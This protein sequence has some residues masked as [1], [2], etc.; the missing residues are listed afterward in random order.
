MNIFY[1]G[2]SG[3]NN[4]TTI[5]INGDNENDIATSMRTIILS[6]LIIYTLKELSIGIA[7]NHNNNGDDCRCLKI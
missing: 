3:E 7:A 6:V 1:F 4:I 5:I 2:D